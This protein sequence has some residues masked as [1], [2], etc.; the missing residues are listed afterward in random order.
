MW[1]DRAPETKL[2]KESAAQ[3]VSFEYIDDC[4]HMYGCEVS[5][6]DTG[7]SGI[8]C[9]NDCIHDISYSPISLEC[10]PTD[11]CRVMEMHEYA[12]EPNDKSSEVIQVQ[13][14]LKQHVEYWEQA[15]YIR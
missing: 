9:G 4:M 13:G 11:D 7:S 10:E 15:I 14:H 2:S 3:T 6:P 8:I 5:S 1:G 12:W